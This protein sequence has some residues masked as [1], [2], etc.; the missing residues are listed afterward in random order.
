VATTA[1]PFS[2]YGTKLVDACV[3]NRTHYCDIT[4]ET[5]WIRRV[6]DRH[7]AQA[8][9]DGTRIIT[10]CGFDSIPS[11]CGS[12]L[13]S[14][15]IREALQ[16][17][18]VSVSAYFRVGGGIN[19]GTVASFFYIIESGEIVMARDPFLL[20]PDPAAHTAEERARNADPAGIHY[21]AELQSWVT[22][23][24]MGMINTR[25]VRRTQALL[26]TRFDY[27]E[28]AKFK[29]S[30][31]ARMVT[32]GGKLFEAIAGSG[33][34]RRI[35]RPLLPHPGDGPS[36]KTMDGGFFECEFIGRAKSGE[37]VRGI[38]KGQGD[39]GNRITVKCLCESA[40]VLA[41]SSTAQSVAKSRPGG[42]LTPVVGLG[43]ELIARLATA[44]I[45]FALV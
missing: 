30:S 40:F 11:D 12:W 22:P 42:V 15:H 44:G 18:C 3:R 13:I 7:H 35:I 28:Y 43:E 33:V 8:S 1:G 37:R 31:T 10:C 36:A 20:D 38:L 39:A 2:L 34:G 29:K 9:T 21:E 41:L 6:I 14:R 23:F 4:G 24:V 17:D 25:V 26:G 27:Q 5:P 16:S 45:T 32:I 19:G